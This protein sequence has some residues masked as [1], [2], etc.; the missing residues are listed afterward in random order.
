LNV[1]DYIVLFDNAVRLA[2][3]VRVNI[4]LTFGKHLV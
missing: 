1:Q 4:S 3:Y 2:V